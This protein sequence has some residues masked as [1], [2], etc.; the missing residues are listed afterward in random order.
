MPRPANSRHK[1]IEAGYEH[2]A[3]Y[4]P[5]KIS[6][7]PISKEIGASRASF[8]HFFSDLE[9]F[10]DALLES[11]FELVHAFIQ[12]GQS[13][14]K[15]LFPDVYQLFSEYSLGLK[16]NRQL[17][18]HRRTP[19]FGFA[20]SKTFDLTTT[21][22]ISDLFIEK[23]NLQLLSKDDVTRIWLLFAECWYTR[24][25]PDNLSAEALQKI[26]IEIMDP[27]MKFVSSSLYFK[28]KNIP[29]M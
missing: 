6:I 11:H 19:V 12:E 8:Y 21:S 14:C 9:N 26:G 27:I 15:K 18:L 4:G 24:M 7:N 23:Y 28:M 13:K 1:W 3:L 5:E 17:F 2:F 22:F 10:F 25:D 16:F 29:Y 20:F